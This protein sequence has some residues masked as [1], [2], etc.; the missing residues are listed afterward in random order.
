MYVNVAE[1]PGATTRRELL[2]TALAASAKPQHQQY[3]GMLAALSRTGPLADAARRTAARK[4]RGDEDSR[5]GDSEGLIPPAK[6]SSKF[7]DPSR[8]P[9]KRRARVA[10]DA[11]GRPASF[12]GSFEECLIAGAQA[13]RSRLKKKWPGCPAFKTTFDDLHK[14]ETV[15]FFFYFVSMCISSSLLSPFSRSLALPCST[16]LLV[17]LKQGIITYT[18]TLL[19][20]SLLSARCLSFLSPLPFLSLSLSPCSIPFSLSLLSLPVLISIS[21]QEP[22]MRWRT[23]KKHV[24]KNGGKRP[25]DELMEINLED[26]AIDDRTAIKLALALRRN[27]SVTS[28][29]LARGC[30]LG[31]LLACPKLNHF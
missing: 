9:A 26:K 24:T 16:D 8:V 22:F 5:N 14:V 15:R 11:S 13:R 19:V 23:S 12:G 30:V 20:L 31:V 3:Y 4:Q 18:P 6:F 21:S 7:N 29:S 2:A 17:L 10:I 27:G 25:I 1:I 28:I